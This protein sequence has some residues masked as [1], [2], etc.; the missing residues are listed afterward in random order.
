MIL[1]QGGEKHPIMIKTL[2][3]LCIL[4]HQHGGGKVGE[5]ADFILELHE[6][7]GSDQIGNVF[8]TVGDVLFKEKPSK[9]VE[10]YNKA[11]EGAQGKSRA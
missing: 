1:V 9:A 2:L 5:I 8:E 7:N 6:E 10:C 11:L 3:Q 4:V